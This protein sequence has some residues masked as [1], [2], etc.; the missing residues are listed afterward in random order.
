MPLTAP[1]LDDRQFTDIKAEALTLIPRYAPEWTNF[2]ES[3]PGIT[4]VELFA[5]LTEILT[6]RLNQVPDLNYIKFLQLI[7]IELNPALP[8]KAELTFALARPDIVSVIVPQGTQVA[9]AG[10]SNQPVIFETDQSLV[11]IGAVLTAVQTF[12]GTGYTPQMS[13]IGNPGQWFYPFGQNPQPGNAVLLGF[14]SPSAFPTDPIDLAV[15]LFQ[16]PLSQPIMKCGA[17]LPPPA[18]IAWEYY[19]GSQWVTINLTSDGTRAFSQ[20]GHVL[21]PGP[22]ANIAASA[23]VAGV[24]QSLYWIRARLVTATYE[25]PPQIGAILTNTVSATQAITFTDEV[26]GGST[27]VPNQ[28]FQV[29]N[30][31]VV[32]LDT[33]LQVTNSDNTQV[34]VTSLR[35]EIDIG[36][37]F[38]VWQ[39]VDDFFSSGPNDRVYMLDLNTGVI[40]T[41]DGE[42]GAI[43]VANLSNPSA[44]VVARSYRSG[45]GS[46]GNVGAD[47]ITQLQTSVQSVNSV[48]NNGPAIGGTDE[49]SVADAKLRASL[50]LQSNDRAVTNSDFEYLATQAPGANVARAFA[51]ALYHPD[52]PNGQIPGVVTVIVVPNAPIPNPVPNQPTPNQ[53]TLQAVCTYLDSHRLLTSEVYVV[54]PVYRKI[55]V[56]VQI[57]VQPGSD[58]AIVQ[59]AVQANLVMFFD[60]LIGGNVQ[61]GVAGTGWTFGGE[62]YYSDVYRVIIQT[63]GVQRIQDNQLLI[64]LDGHLQTF[65]RD[66]P[67]NKGELLYSDGKGHVVDVSYSTSS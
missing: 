33:P 22:G 48:T 46:Q 32:V 9:A 59:N 49:E 42:H 65:C 27:G 6:Y 61:P 26:L 63:P 21:F 40:T 13:Q 37:G 56:Q 28:T 19:S 60:P 1:N 38:M 31:P 62:I 15:N 10:G 24:A 12:N 35:L 47:T 36:Q 30:T 67:I 25:M 11:A 20:N 53:T 43:P 50:A 57:L 18:T 4:L 5:W 54:G 41:G 39:Q 58:L 2:N 55:Q 8:A 44:N 23:N 29:T 64:Y 16:D 14:S 17:A 34:T 51:I 52:F 66:V 7:G 3:D 45:G